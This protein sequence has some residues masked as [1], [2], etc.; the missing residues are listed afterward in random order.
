MKFT[1]GQFLRYGDIQLAERENSEI[2]VFS[3]GGPI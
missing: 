1:E 2:Q 3:H